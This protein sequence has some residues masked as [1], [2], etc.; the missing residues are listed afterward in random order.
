AVPNQP[1]AAPL[2]NGGNPGPLTGKIM[3]VDR[4]GTSFTDMMNK[5]NAAGAVGVIVDNFN[6][7]TSPPIVMSTAGQPPGITDVMISKADRDTIVAAAGGFN[8]TTGLPTNPTNVTIQPDP[9]TTHIFP[10]NG[11]GSA[12]GTGSPDT[13]P[14]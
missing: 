13:V 1:T 12:A 4:G 11:A 10:P 9:L 7:P 8:A 6:N 14:S 5:A 3:M 2:T